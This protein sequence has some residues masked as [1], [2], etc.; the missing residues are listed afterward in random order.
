M[1]AGIVFRS[2]G[3]VQICLQTENLKNVGLKRIFRPKPLCDG[4]IC[5]FPYGKKWH[6]IKFELHS[7]IQPGLLVP[8]SHARMIECR[9]VEADGGH[10]LLKSLMH[11]MAGIRG[12]FRASVPPAVRN[13]LVLALYLDDLRDTQH[14]H[15]ETATLSTCLSLAVLPLTT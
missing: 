1:G 5:F 2:W 4:P 3:E 15:C 6:K 11:G 7:I 8:H 12:S 9:S 13:R 10:G 14:A